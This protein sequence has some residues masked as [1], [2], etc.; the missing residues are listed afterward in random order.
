M[1]NRNGK[2]KWETKWEIKG[3]QK[4]DK[5]RFYPYV[6]ATQTNCMQDSFTLSPFH[7]INLTLLAQ[8]TNQGL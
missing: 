1:G 4:W 2:Q 7:G 8:H 6:Y 3:K 5:V